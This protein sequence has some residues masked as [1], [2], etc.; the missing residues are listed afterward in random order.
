M[1]RSNIH[2]ILL[3]AFLLAVMLYGTGCVQNKPVIATPDGSQ[4]N[5]YSAYLYSA[6]DVL[7][8][9]G[10]FAGAES[11]FRMA[12]RYDPQSLEIKKALFNVLLNRA[13][14]QEIPL[15]HLGNYVDSLLVQKAMDKTMLEQA[16][17]TFAKAEDNLKAKYLLEIYLKKYATAR[18]YT[19][20]FYLEQTLYGKSR[21]ELLQKAYKLAGSDAQFL[22]SLGYLYMAFDST[23][24]ENVW[25]TARKYDTTT[26]SA[27]FLWGLYSKDNNSV[28]LHK[29]WKSFRLPDEKEKLIQIVNGAFDNGEFNSL[30]LLSDVILASDDP[31]F[32]LYLLQA[33]WYA[34]ENKLFERSWN[35]LQAMQLDKLD[36]QLAFFYATL[37]YLKTDNYPAALNWLSKLNGKNSLD[38]AVNLYRATRLMN[39]EQ[40]DSTGIAAVKDILYKTIEPAT[41]QQ[42][43]AP[44]KR[45]LLAVIDSLQYDNAISL[46]DSI[47]LQCVEWFYKND[48]RTYDTYIWLAMYF[49]R[50]KQ[51]TRAKAL[52]REA[53]DEYPEDAALLNWL[54]YG[55]V[56][57]GDNLEEAEVLIRRALQLS[58]DNP[59]YL[60]S[61]A[62]LY[63]VKGDFQQAVSLMEIPSQLEK[64]PSEIAWHLGSIYNS[65]ND[66][67]KAIQY[68]KLAI[69]INDDPDYAA[70]SKAM[71][72]SIQP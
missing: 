57:T 69:E 45:Y 32:T 64:M 47:T 42:L 51:D 27:Q 20:L 63:Y 35:K 18:A 55:Y 39:S 16:Y 53:L 17:N 66:K 41:E 22:N 54:G 25:L 9:N 72:E 30:I 37:Y 26:A 34:N 71:I 28:K 33:S 21:P 4:P 19:S 52:L 5:E 62:W 40:T 13:E 61:L 31:Q 46:P 38:E 56:L 50:T 1:K 12:S 7:Y 67:E 68:L 43:T 10:D 49:N 8:L 70:K 59:Y 2:S 23:K 24:A 29:L 36:S 6:G 58:P 65:V 60:D 15:A 14:N 11:V 44:V 3:Y 48:R